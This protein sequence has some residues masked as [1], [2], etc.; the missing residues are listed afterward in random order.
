MN[1][2]EWTCPNCGAIWGFDE[3][4][5]EECNCCGYPHCEDYNSDMDE[6]VD[7]PYYEY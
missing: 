1:V 3:W 5:F 6:D 2:E 7:P 4:Q